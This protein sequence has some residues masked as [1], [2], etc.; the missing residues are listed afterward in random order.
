MQ[1]V[2]HSPDDQRRAFNPL[3]SSDHI[4][5]QLFPE[6]RVLQER[7]PVLC[8]END[9]QKD[10]RQAL[11]HGFILP[12]LEF[13]PVGALQIFTAIIPRADAPWA[14]ESRPV[15]AKARLRRR[16]GMTEVL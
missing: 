11:R 8:A 15:G 3:E 1:M 6:G 14:I 7:R 5:I 13:R 9:V 10:I 4:S 16:P 2:F 12:N